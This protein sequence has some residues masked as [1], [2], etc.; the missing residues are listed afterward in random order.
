MP[1]VGYPGWLPAI[2]ANT[3]KHVCFAMSDGRRHIPCRIS[4]N[5]LRDCFGEENSD[6]LDLFESCQGEIEDAASRKFLGNNI[7]NE[8]IELEEGDFD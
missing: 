5:T 6:P 2:D 4:I 1:I 7:S 3:R 8:L